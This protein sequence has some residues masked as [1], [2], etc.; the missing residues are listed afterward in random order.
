MAGVSLSDTPGV[1]DQGPNWSIDRSALD[2]PLGWLSGD[3]CDA[4]EI[5]VIVQ[6]RERGGL[7]DCGDEEIGDLASLESVGGEVALD[8]LRA[9]EVMCFDIDSLGGATDRRCLR[10]RS[11]DGAL[12]DARRS[13]ECFARAVWMGLNW[14]RYERRRPCRHP[15]QGSERPHRSSPSWWPSPGS[16]RTHQRW[17]ASHVSVASGSRS[18][19]LLRWSLTE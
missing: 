3:G 9:I 1:G 4:V 2:D 18:Q 13:S 8:L 14:C 15:M 17:L 11:L 16:P 12:R 10:G 6:D 19:P 5:C 7:G